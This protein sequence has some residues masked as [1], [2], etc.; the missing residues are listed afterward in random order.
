M[1]S[2]HL[3]IKCLS[4]TFLFS[5]FVILQPMLQ[6]SVLAE[7]EKR[8]E[9]EISTTIDETSSR[10][11]E[12]EAQMTDN[13]EEAAPSDTAMSESTKGTLIL[14]AGCVLFFCNPYGF[15]AILGTAAIVRVGYGLL[16]AIRNGQYD[17]ASFSDGSPE[18]LES[19]R[20]KD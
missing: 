18:E 2:H 7:D 17:S 13:R 11:P 19:V 20:D 4:M 15:I 3:R 16:E 9:S 6:R 8:R 12:N 5:S 10:Q 14:I 1:L